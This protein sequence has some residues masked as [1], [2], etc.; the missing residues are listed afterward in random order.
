MKVRG[1]ELSRFFA[2]WPMGDNWYVNDGGWEEDDAGDPVLVA[3]ASYDLLDIV[4][5]LSWQGLS[6]GSP[7]AMPDVVKIGTEE[8]RT[9]ELGLSVSRVWRAWKKMRT[10]QTFLVEV[11]VEDASEFAVLVRARKWRTK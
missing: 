5:N 8:I 11:P 10:H 3:G 1:H 6:E 4:P 2:D 7:S 9:G